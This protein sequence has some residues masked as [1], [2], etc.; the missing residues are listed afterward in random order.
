MQAGV[1]QGSVLSPLVYILYVNY[2]LQTPIVYLALF[3][4][5]TCL[6]ATERYGAVSAQWRSSVSAGT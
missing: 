5:H 4:D 1:P 6:Y 3:A 2:A